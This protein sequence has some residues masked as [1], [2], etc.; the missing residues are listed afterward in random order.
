MSGNADCIPRG[1]LLAN[2]HHG[3]LVNEIL[4][5]RKRNLLA[6]SEIGTGSGM[7]MRVV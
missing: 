4:P 7:R 1:T 6:V 3:D 2:D 5:V